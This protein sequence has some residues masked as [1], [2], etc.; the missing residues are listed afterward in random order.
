MTR[1]STKKLFQSQEGQV[2]HQDEL[3]FTVDSVSLVNQEMF[4]VRAS[5]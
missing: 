2:E 5:L 1:R 3:I 4:L